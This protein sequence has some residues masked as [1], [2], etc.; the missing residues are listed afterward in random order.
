MPRV[1]VHQRKGE[2]CADDEAGTTGCGGSKQLGM[3]EG[4]AG[5]SMVS[6]MIMSATVAEVNEHALPTV[7]CAAAP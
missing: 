2:K 7:A 5:Q 6:D 3:E 1:G 4:T